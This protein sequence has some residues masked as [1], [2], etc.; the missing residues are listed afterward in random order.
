MR[1]PPCKES[2]CAADKR[3]EHGKAAIPTNRTFH[4]QRCA[5][6]GVELTLIG[7]L[8]SADREAANRTRRNPT[9]DWRQ[10]CGYPHRGFESHPLRQLVSCFSREISPSEIV[11]EDPRVSPTQFRASGR[12]E[13]RLGITEAPSVPNSPFGNLAVRLGRVPGLHSCLLGANTGPRLSSARSR[14]Y[15]A[16][17]G[18]VSIFVTGG[19]FHLPDSASNFGA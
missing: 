13:R 2:F 14:R 6:D 10:L 9:P 18:I 8:N 17:M 1:V 5:I 12:R 3:S 4:V 15:C 19:G 7:S 16:V 11:T